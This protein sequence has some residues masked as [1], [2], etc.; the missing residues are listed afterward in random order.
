MP[1]KPTA[2]RP[3]DR[4]ALVAPSGASDRERLARG[5]ELL[6][7]WDLRVD[8]VA[9]PIGMRYFA[10][11]DAE[12]ARQVRE[13]FQDPGVRAI[14]AMR[15]GYGAARLYDHVDIG[16][17]AF[18]P[19]IFVG[20][21]DITILLNRLVQEAD[22]VT[23]H[24][25]MVAV[26]LPR[27]NAA[28]RDRFR[29]FLFGEDGWWDGGARETWRA[30]EAQGPLVGGCLSVLVTTLG[31]PYEIQT[32]GAVLFL[33]DVAE[34]PYRIDRMLNHLKHAGKLDGVRAVVL[35]PMLDCDGGEG[36]RILREI[37]LDALSHVEV[38]ILYGIEAGHGTENVVLPFGCRVRVAP[39]EPRL[40]LLEPVFA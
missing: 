36:S 38:P 16:A 10:A 23:Y 14:L 7:A 9:Q 33:E 20:F 29:R 34:R 11:A 25:P 39:D 40:D 13:A 12:R 31:T 1:R 35:G 18:D 32:D 19:K 17:L 37:F 4:V 24:G 22:V 26:D 15:G 28:A 2:L 6:S 21:S 5:I 8:A 30:G 27:L 3:G